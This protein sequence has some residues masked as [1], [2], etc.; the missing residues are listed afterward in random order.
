MSYHLFINYTYLIVE[1]NSGHAIV[2]DPAWELD[3]ITQQLEKAHANLRAILLTHSHYDHVN[4]VPTLSDWMQPDVFMSQ[5]EID[6]SGF[7]CK[8]LHA[9]NDKDRLLLGE[10]PFHCLLTP[11]HTAGSMCFQLEKSLF[12]GDTLFTEGCG[13]CPVPGGSPEAMYL[14]MQRLKAEIKDDVRIFPGH[15]FGMSPGQTMGH[16]CKNNIYLQLNREHFI[17]FRMRK[18]QQ[19]LFD[20]Q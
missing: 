18:N 13:A 12:T 3:K 6:A 7:R 14:S 2:V 19:G 17:R 16:L 4:L 8:R 20:F 9:V 11:G 5:K 15:S 10:L 1:P